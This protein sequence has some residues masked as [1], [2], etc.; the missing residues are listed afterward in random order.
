MFFLD[1]L[2]SK[3]TI[4]HESIFFNSFKSL[5]IVP[6]EFA[7]SKCTN[8]FSRKSMQAQSVP[9]YSMSLLHQLS[10]AKSLVWAGATEKMGLP[11][12]APSSQ[13]K[14]MTSS[15]DFYPSPPHPSFILQK[16]YSRQTQF[17]VITHPSPQSSVL[18]QSSLKKS[19]ALQ[20]RCSG[21]EFLHRRK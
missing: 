7:N 16:L 20:L 3:T 6:W 1:P 18:G 17:R 10:V 19:R 11:H 14:V 15:C 21:T 9:F 8:I 13:S 5:G 2:P 4:T 12:C